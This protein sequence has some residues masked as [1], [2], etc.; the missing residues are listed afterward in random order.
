MGEISIYN[1]S[2]NKNEIKNLIEGKGSS[3]GLVEKWGIG[4]GRGGIAESISGKHNG[5]IKNGT[6]VG[7][8]VLDY[9]PLRYLEF[10]RGDYVGIENGEGRLDILENDFSIS[11]WVRTDN[12]DGGEH[13]IYSAG[14]GV[15][16]TPVYMEMY[17]NRLSLTVGGAWYE[18]KFNIADGE[19]HHVVGM[20]DRDKGMGIYVDGELDWTARVEK[21]EIKTN[22]EKEIYVG[23]YAGGGYYWDGGISE[24][25]I[26]NRYL[27]PEEI[28]ELYIGEEVETGKVNSWGLDYVEEE[29]VRSETGVNTGKNHGAE[30]REEEKI[31]AEYP[32]EYL[33]LDS[34][35]EY[36]DI[37][38]GEIIDIGESDFTISGWVRAEGRDGGEHMIYSAGKGGV[39]SEID[40]PVYMEMYENKLSMSVGGVWYQS[41]VDIG[42]G[43]W[44]Y[45]AGIMDRDKG[46]RIYVDGEVEEGGRPETSD[47]KFSSRGRIG[48]YAG[49]G[50]GWRG[51]IGEIEVYGRSVSV[52]ELDRK[53]ESGSL[54]EGCKTRWGF[55]I[56]ETEKEEWEKIT[57]N[58]NTI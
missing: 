13:M 58:R 8:G 52:E 43:E 3:A 46:I 15:G 25:K 12:T 7:A 44:H 10:E 47:L 23:R 33:T 19:W 22:H 38:S 14:S 2:L 5:A 30:Y 50:Y 37:G 26:Y 31:S 17:E 34:L 11:A 20:M 35:G 51:D 40:K 48:S 28:Y 18:S 4:E 27:Y 39:N 55:E 16:E 32:I 56:E 6:W 45:V 36:A 24:V 53:R 41:K 1:K 57:N 42:D 9:E 21:S 54:I 49:G 29:L